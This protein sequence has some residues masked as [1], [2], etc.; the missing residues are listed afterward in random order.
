[1]NLPSDASSKE[2]ILV[3]ASQ[4]LRTVLYRHTEKHHVPLTST[5]LR[6]C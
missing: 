1:V 6:M 5:D 3:E 2:S 4:L